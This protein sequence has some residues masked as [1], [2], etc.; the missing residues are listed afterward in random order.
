MDDHPTAGEIRRFV[1]GRLEAGTAS[2]RVVRH[3]LSACPVCQS[4]VRRRFS[5]R[6]PREELAAGETLLEAIRRAAPELVDRV[7]AERIRAPALLRELLRHPP[8]RQQLIVR[9]RRRFQTAALVRDLCEESHRRVGEDPDEAVRLAELAAL[10]ADSLPA[11]RYPLELINDLRCRARAWLSNAQRRASDLAAAERSLGS[12]YALYRQG[13]RDPVELALLR[14]REALLR[15]DQGRSLEALEAND[16][17]YQLY[18]SLGDRHMA[19]KMLIDRS[20]MLCEAGRPHRAI[21]AAAVAATLVEPERE[22]KV[23]LAIYHDL[24]LAYSEAGQLDEALGCLR[25]AAGLYEEVGSRSEQL[26]RHWLEGSVLLKQRRLHEAACQFRIAQ[27]GFAELG[28][29]FEAAHVSLELAATYAELGWT[30]QVRRLAEEVLAIF[31]SRRLHREAIAALV[32]LVR[33][34][35]EDRETALAVRAVSRF[36]E[37]LESDP[38]RRFRPRPPRKGSVQGPGALLPEQSLLR[39]P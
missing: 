24:A 32:F 37:E 21:R 15:S 10:V 22:P 27:E 33:A 11:S 28:L 39:S 25:D 35:D 26:R 31:R 23:V 30:Q 5:D 13:S 16:R 6:P 34:A 18:R 7:A 38:S 2:R 29:A 19:G 3:L 36:L 17:A 8:P 20:V 1:E 14:G 9:H 12:A 4:I